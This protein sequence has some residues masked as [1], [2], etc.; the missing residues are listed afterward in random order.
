M[1]KRYEGSIIAGKSPAESKKPAGKAPAEPR[2]L[3]EL[4]HYHRGV[5]VAE[6]LDIPRHVV[7]HY[8]RGTHRYPNRE[9]YTKIVRYLHQHAID[10]LA[11]IEREAS[12]VRID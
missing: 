11:A 1:N 7:S 2:K 12:D 8:Q 3:H 10:I 5:T 4:L 6:E 9:A